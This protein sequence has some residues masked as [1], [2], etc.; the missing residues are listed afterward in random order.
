MR[1][2]LWL[3]LWLCLA[4][5]AL[6]AP[7][8]EVLDNG[9]T[10]VL[11]EDHSAPVATV[12]L[13][14]GTGS[15]REGEYLGTGISHLLEHVISDGSQTRTREQIEQEQA[16]LGNNANA[17]TS[18]DV[19]S[20]YVI[21]SG[22]QTLAALDHLADFVFHPTFPAEAVQTQQGI[23]AREM[24]RGQDDPGRE[25][26][27]EFA[28]LMF[29]VSPAGARIIGTLDQFQRLTRDDLVRLHQRYYAPGNMV[30]TVV[31]DFDTATVLGHIRQ[32]LA[33][34]PERVTP[35]AAL[36][37]EPPQLS[38]RRSERHQAGLSRAYFML[39]Y[40]TVSLFSPDMYP[41]DVAAYVLTNGGASRLVSQLRDEQ[42]L[43]D[44]VSSASATP[45]YDAGYFAV[46]AETT[47]E[48]VA[49]AEQ[50]ILAALQRLGREPVSAAELARAKRQKEADLVFSG[51][52]TQGRAER[53]GNDLLT[54]GDLH[55]SE[56]YVE[57][58][59]RVTAADIQRV[60]RRYFIPAHYNFALL[61]PPEA[62]P[63]AATPSAQAPSASAA[64]SIHEARLSNGLRLLV[65]ENHAVP[66]VNFFAAA[67]GGL[68]Y[69]SE[70]NAGL[71]SL[72]SAMLVR[73]TRT[74]SRLQIA[75]ALENVGGVLSPY[76]GRNSF[77]VSA[78]VRSEDLPLALTLA[79]D[80]L[81][82]PTFPEE[83][84]QQQKQL[85]LAALAARADDVD[86]WAS[87][88]MLQTLFAQ[89]PYRTPTAGKRESVE[90]LTRQDL[91]SFHQALVRPET[92]VLAIFGD[93]T[94]AQAQALAERAF[95][96]MQGHGATLQPAPAEP[97]PAEPRV[98]T[99]ARAQQQA[100]IT[101]GFRAGT[102]TD[103]SRYAR[104]VMTA[105]FAG[106][107]YPGGRLH[108]AL[109][110]AQLVY[111]TW[112]YAVPGPDTGFYVIYAGTAP[113]KAAAAQQRIEQLVRELQ[114]QPPTAEELALAK[115]VAIANH[116]VGLESSGDRAQAVALD[117]LYGLGP[118][119]IF[120]YADE[121]NKV[122]A[123]QVQEQA[124]TILDWPH[125][126]QIVT[127]P[128][129]DRP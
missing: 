39:G 71:T 55:F 87:D 58:I 35:R 15:V 59:R 105:V 64:A 4:T 37:S 74:R 51:V 90:R 83:E 19:V 34:L 92:M 108:T 47:P 61:A 97:P 116:A 30:L 31:G 78:Q 3:S 122:T 26:Y 27:Y 52:T 21:T 62:S 41:L 48:K 50:A 24:A 32:T 120:R 124:R 54:A 82:H 85:Q 114:A 8:Q 79:A 18:T 9:L 45:A 111:A 84:L 101:Y 22:P 88:L 49:A 46:S 25:L 57:G 23:I 118:G 107:G 69:E 44:A 38:P 86:T 94:P 115:T 89:Y 56:R 112:A 125:R 109:R 2:A 110:G 91:L 77:G 76:S 66:V 14:V 102:V 10:V 68:R 106:L 33:P 11:D 16:R 65:Q 93:T 40:P 75:Q 53:Y 81:A 126:V 20:Y 63:T 6:A 12:Q 96:Q 70:R 36:P 80:V 72:M 17:Y 104:D 129:Q 7:R 99:V 73:G 29:R 100:I 67:P 119:E 127:T 113:E 42:G 98:Q 1:R 123:A 103:A 60:A 117:V 13:F 95:G 128:Q 43:V 28:G 5:W 121:I